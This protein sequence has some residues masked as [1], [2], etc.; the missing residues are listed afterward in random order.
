MNR[1][2]V[3]DHDEALRTA[4]AATLQQQGFEVLQATTGVEGM[5]IARTAAPNLILCD[6]DLQGVGGSLIL[7]AVR[8][9]PKLASIPFVLMSRFAV[10][11]DPP[12]G[13]E[14]GADGF[15]SKPV[16]PMALATAI[17]VCLNKHAETIV[18]VQTS[19]SGAPS[20]VGSGPWE[21]LLNALRPVVESTQIICTAYNQLD[22]QEIVELA[23]RAHQAASQLYQKL[24]SWLPVTEHGR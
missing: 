5:Q 2:L 3:I 10:S 21:L 22:P 14:K 18:Q 6:V 19:P 13:I 20:E 16:T 11:E 7:F 12:D 1:I 23:T 8:R 9:D 17:D 15:L 24:E 4:L